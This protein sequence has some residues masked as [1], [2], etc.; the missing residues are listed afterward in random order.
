MKII[1]IDSGLHIAQIQLPAN[2]QVDET[3]S[4][5]E[6]WNAY[7]HVAATVNYGTDFLKKRRFLPQGTKCIDVFRVQL[8][9]QSSSRGLF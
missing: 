4:L 8:H 1:E 5:P 9:S 6:E 7:P 2:A 3:Q